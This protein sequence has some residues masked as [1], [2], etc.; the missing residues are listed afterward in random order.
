MKKN[1]K[2]VLA[3]GLATSMVIGMSIPACAAEAKYTDESSKTFTKIYESIGDG[4]YSPA[5]TFEF[6]NI[7]FEGATETGEGYDEEWAASHLPKISKV[8]YEKSK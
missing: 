4:A 7:K 1:L 8:S 5:E 3:A 2:K 6:E